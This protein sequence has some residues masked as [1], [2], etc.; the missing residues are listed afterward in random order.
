MEQEH[1][2]Q[3]ACAVILAAGDG[4]RMKSSAPKVLCRVLFKPMISWVS[5]SV[6]QAGIRHACVVVGTGA[7]AVQVAS[8]LPGG[9]STAVQAERRGTGHAAM[10]AA[11]YIR[12]GGFSHVAVLC[13]D[14]PLIGAE[15]LS[16]SFRQHLSEGNDCTVLAARVADPTGYGRIVRENGRVR[17]VVEQADA[18]EEIRLINEI[19]SGDFWFRADFL[20]EALER[21]TDNNA[22]GEYYLT[23]CVSY[24]VENGYSVGACVVGSDAV[25]GAN[26][27]KALT[28]LNRAALE[29]VLDRHMENGVDIPFPD[30]IV[31]GA[32]V[33]IGP[34][35]AILPGTILR[36]R[37]I[38][39][40]GCEIGPNS[41]L[42]SA[43]IGD[44]C[45]V[46]ASYI[47]S[48]NLE[49]G[50]KIGPMS[51]V[52]PG[53][54][55]HEKVKIGDFVEVKNSTIGAGTS[56]AHLTYV[57]DSDVGEC[58]NFG[59][60]VVTVNYDGASK[61]RTVIGDH[62][63]IGCNT[64]LV[65]PVKV[66]NRAYSAAGTTV[67]EDV[68]DGALVIGRSR[69]TVKENWPGPP[70]AGNKRAG[71]KPDPNAPA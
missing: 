30:G 58:V 56:V 32:D 17:A 53:S 16:R 26:S 54:H 59:C 48:S 3:K 60:G 14:A 31:I 40:S 25:L 15:E 41:Y 57:G 11:D 35:T 7:G 37:T 61:H 49:A 68:P 19:N 42:D 43:V 39:G 55:I 34:D 5:D 2:I 47:D 27:R 20:L 29:K 71:L 22:Q 28:A 13:G 70:E 63:F 6:R 18:G 23:D 12:A 65:A 8:L 64:N 46:V 52:R 9:F 36:G 67:T 4:K 45:R 66:G 33:E 44:N 62:A 24:G 51:N 50:V 10:M 38:I 1:A 21:L 69:Q